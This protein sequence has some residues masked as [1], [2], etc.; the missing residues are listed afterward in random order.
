MQIKNMLYERRRPAMKK[1]ISFILTVAM[2]IACMPACVFADEPDSV[3][4]IGEY[5]LDAA[6]PDNDNL[7]G[8]T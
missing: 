5:T 7:P 8:I 1:F 3:V 4:T 6:H 2:I